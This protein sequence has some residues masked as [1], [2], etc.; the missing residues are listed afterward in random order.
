MRMAYSVSKMNALATD[1][2]FCHGFHLQAFYTLN[3]T[4]VKDKDGKD[5]A[6]S[7]GSSDGGSDGSSDGEDTLGDP[8]D[9]TFDPGDP[10]DETKAPYGPH[11]Y[12][13]TPTTLSGMGVPNG[14]SEVVP[15][16]ATPVPSKPS[17]PKATKP[18]PTPVGLR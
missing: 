7:D 16:P 5:A 4:L 12:H 6:G 18:S 8:L 1:I 13:P 9:Q 11:E 14:A 15:P 2:T 3:T 17:K 10:T